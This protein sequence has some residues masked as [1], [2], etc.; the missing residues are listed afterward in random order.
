MKFRNLAAAA[1][2]LALSTT[3]VLAQATVSDLSRAAAPVSGES[4][5]GGDS[6]LLLILAVV[7]FGGGIFLL[8][9]NNDDTP[10]S[11]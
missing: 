9:D 10:A 7:L 8:A 2:A 3:P 4:Q 6:T 11:P 5:F 1:A